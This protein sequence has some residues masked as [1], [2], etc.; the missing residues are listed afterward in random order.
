MSSKLNVL[1]RCQDWQ[2]CLGMPDVV[3]VRLR[4]LFYVT[5]CRSDLDYILVDG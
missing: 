1:L 5:R 2:R 3:L 4:L